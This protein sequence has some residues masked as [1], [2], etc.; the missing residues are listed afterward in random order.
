LDD[1]LTDF[2]IPPFPPLARKGPFAL[3]AGTGVSPPPTRSPSGETP[4]PAAGPCPPRQR[5]WSFSNNPPHGFARTTDHRHPGTTR[6]KYFSFPVLPSFGGT[7]RA[8]MG[9]TAGKPDA[10][11]HPRA[12]PVARASHYQPFNFPQ[13]CLCERAPIM[14]WGRGKPLWPAGCRT[15]G[16]VVGK[17]PGSA[18]TETHTSQLPDSLGCLSDLLFSTQ[19]TDG[20]GPPAFRETSL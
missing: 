19:T 16:G 9:P 1:C 2:Q 15:G 10:P 6:P 13:L 17:G 20:V 3:S 7:S 11:P 18:H 4:P 12:V 8:R 5:P 14:R